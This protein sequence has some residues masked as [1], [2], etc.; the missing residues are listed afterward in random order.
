[1]TPFSLKLSGL[2]A[3]PDAKEGRVIW[4]G[5]QN[6]KEL[7][8]LQQDQEDQLRNLDLFLEERSYRP[9]LTLLRLRSAKNFTDILSPHRDQQFGSL[10]VLELVLYESTLGGPFPVYKPLERFELVARSSD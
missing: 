9:H 4:M 1:M 10:Q 5:V 8:S 2:D 6:S 7:R 3:F